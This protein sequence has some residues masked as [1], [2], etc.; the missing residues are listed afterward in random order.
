MAKAAG[1]DWSTNIFVGCA[2]E[3]ACNTYVNGEIDVA[4]PYD[5]CNTVEKNLE[6]LIIGDFIIICEFADAHIELVEQCEIDHIAAPVAL[7]SQDAR[8][9]MKMSNT[10]DYLSMLHLY[11]KLVG[12]LEN[13]T[14]LLALHQLNTAIQNLKQQLRMALLDGEDSPFLQCLPRSYEDVLNS[15]IIAGWPTQPVR[16]LPTGCEC[17]D[18][19]EDE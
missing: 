11:L 9:H 6:N 8:C 19:P 12:Q 4:N 18:P 10:S 3:T 1:W 2:A 13:A 14:S 5:Y 15:D 16:N 7:P 17:P